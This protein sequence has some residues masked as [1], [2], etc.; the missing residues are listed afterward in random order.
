MS[1]GPIKRAREGVHPAVE[2]LWDHI[3]NDRRPLWQIAELAGVGDRAMRDWRQGVS[4]P[5]LV[6]LEAA[7]GVY[8]YRMT[9]E[10]EG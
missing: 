8:G 2:L 7:L 9:M 6:D 5:R 4:S 1:K 3:A 10:K